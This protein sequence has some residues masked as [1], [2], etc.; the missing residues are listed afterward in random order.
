MI[1]LDAAWITQSLDE[2]DVARYTVT[3]NT[4][5]IEQNIAYP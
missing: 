3:S 5:Y 1:Q 4:L 2:D